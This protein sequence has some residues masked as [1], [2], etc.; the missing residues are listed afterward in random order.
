[1]KILHTADWH[2]G[3][4]IHEQSL[5]EDQKHIL[6]ELIEIIENK[7]PD[8]MIIAGDIYDR[9]QPPIEAI[10]LLDEVLSE[11]I[12]V[13]KLPVIAISGNHDNP[14]RIGFASKIL[15]DNGLHMVGEME[16]DAAPIVI[17]DEY[18]AVNFYAV[19]YAEHAKIREMYDDSEIKSQSDAINKI[20]NKIYETMDE[21]GRNV[22]IA[23]SYIGSMY[24]LEQSDSER[25]LSVGGTEIV[26]A[27]YFDKFNYTALGHLHKGQKALN[28]N[29]RYSGSILK[30]SFS[31]NRHIKSVTMVEIDAHGD[32][33]YEQIALTPVR[34]MR[35]IKGKLDE[36]T[37]KN[38]YS[39]ANINDYIKAVLTDEGELLEPMYAL[40]SVY[41]N[42]L[43]MEKQSNMN[44]GDDMGDG[45]SEYTKKPPLEIAKEFY[46][47]VT[48]NKFD[49]SRREIVSKVL[50][51]IME[52]ERM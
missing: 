4:I 7:K 12:L 49:D 26:D 9:S 47:D 19:P 32:V 27:K 43:K 46:E 21:S 17:N 42:I 10:E 48:G 38:V 23:H 1:M 35:I 6:N 41:P 36:L 31:E 34:D 33:D 15:K 44:Q 20:V 5:L 50:S 30:Y 24:G 14:I 40:R 11:V 45:A 22:C 3:K 51:N 39:K 2:L 28:D 8:V 25:Q 29:I 52:G 13:R 37:S 18:G 16:G